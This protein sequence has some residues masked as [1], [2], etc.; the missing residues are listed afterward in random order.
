M[1]KEIE[2]FDYDG[3]DGTLIIT[4]SRLIFIHNEQG[5]KEIKFSDIQ[6]CTLKIE[7]GRY[8]DITNLEIGI[9]FTTDTF[10]A[11]LGSDQYKDLARYILSAIKEVN[12]QEDYGIDIEDETPS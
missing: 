1:E 2:R 8:S 12:E 4:D 7:P 11:R 10:K 9:K 6:R 5:R 3:G